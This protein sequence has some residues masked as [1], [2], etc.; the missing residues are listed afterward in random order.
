MTD[1]GN[2]RASNQDRIV[3]DIV[4]CGDA[5]IPAALLL[6]ADGLGGHEGGE[7]ASSLAEETLRD[8][9]AAPLASGKITATGISRM[10][11]G[12]VKLANKR[13]YEV[14]SDGYGAN[15]PGTT[16]TA[17][18]LSGHRYDI[19]HVG[20]SRAYMIT[21]HSTLQLTDDDS[22]VADAVRLGH[23]TVEQARTSPYRNQLTR[24]VGTSE[25]VEPSIYHGPIDPGDVIALCSDGL[26]EYITG[27][28]MHRLIFDYATLQQY[29]EHLVQLA[30]QRGGHDNI[31]VV[32]ARAS[33]WDERQ[34]EVGKARERLSKSKKRTTLPLLHAFRHKH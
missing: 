17:C 29:C 11:A 6:V 4:R 31:S 10:L 12:A 34:T 30:K 5:G 18:V 9:V 26:S 2:V 28:E 8:T 14:G 33:S 19:A 32:A 7:M 15:R 27:D 24:S 20:D 25:S 23:L 3:A 1:I 22:V 16:M 21:P 13:V